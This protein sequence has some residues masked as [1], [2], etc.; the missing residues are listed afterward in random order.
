VIGNNVKKIGENAFNSTGIRTYY[1]A[2]VEYNGSAAKEGEIKV[3]KIAENVFYEADSAKWQKVSVAASVANITGKT[4]SYYSANIKYGNVA[5]SGSNDIVA[6]GQGNLYIVDKENARIVVL[7]KYQY[8]VIGVM[9]TWTDEFGNTQTFKNPTGVYVT[10][11]NKMV[12]GSSHI[13]VCDTGNRRIVVFDESYNYVRTITAPASALLD[14]DDFTPYAIAVDIYGRIFIVSRNCH[15]GV[16][17]L[18]NDG[19]F[20]GF[21]GA[22]KVTV[23]SIQA[24]WEKINPTNEDEKTSFNLSI[25]FNNITVDDQGFVYVT[26]NFTEKEDKS[27]QLDAIKAKESAYS[28]VK[29]LNST[30]VE[31][32]NRNGFFDPGG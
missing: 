15:Q 31:I 24:L 25:P 5:L 22:Q 11:E 29:K 18:S 28:P 3:N 23:D 32:M 9:R 16:I 4:L 19:D 14:E 13:F 7:D 12:D 27:K 26:I 2:A 6:D 21:I 10:D 17:V 30:G 20:T 8:N 1:D